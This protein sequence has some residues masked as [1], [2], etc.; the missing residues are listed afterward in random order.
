MLPSFSSTV[1]DV[2]H[3]EHLRIKA[4]SDIDIKISTTSLFSCLNSFPGVISLFVPLP[5]QDEEMSHLRSFNPPFST[6]VFIGNVKKF[7]L[8]PFQKVPTE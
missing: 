3:L 4:Q 1:I 7:T 6:R 8:P 2:V 5:A